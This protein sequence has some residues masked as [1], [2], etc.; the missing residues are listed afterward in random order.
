MDE[1]IKYI[2]VISTGLATICALYIFLATIVWK[3]KG[4]VGFHNN[5][6]LPMVFALLI[7]ALYYEK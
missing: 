4:F 2:F 3:E 1:L 6:Q 5:W 7:D